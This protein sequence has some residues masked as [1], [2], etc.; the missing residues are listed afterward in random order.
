MFQVE[1]GA[2]ALNTGKQSKTVTLQAE[3]KRIIQ[4]WGRDRPLK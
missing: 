1:A 3:A 2:T 4:A